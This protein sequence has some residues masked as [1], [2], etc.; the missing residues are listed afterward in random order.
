ML[1]DAPRLQQVFENLITNA[2]QQSAPDTLVI[3]ESRDIT[4]DQ[5]KFIECD[6]RDYGIGFDPQ[7][8]PRIFQ[9]FFTRR[10]GGTGLGLSIVQRIVEQHGGTIEATNAPDGGAVLRMRFPAVPMRR[11]GQKRMGSQGTPPG[12]ERERGLE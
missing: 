11:T 4:V 10:R 5:R 2:I 3:V 7:D 9:P 1:I 12:D 6:V 8:L